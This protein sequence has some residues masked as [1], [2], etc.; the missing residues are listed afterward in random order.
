MSEIFTLFLWA[1]WQD[2]ENQTSYT[3][4][5]IIQETLY[6]DLRGIKLQENGE[7]LHN[8]ELHNLHSSPNI[9]MMKSRSLK[10]VG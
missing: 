2:F 9:R 6:L 4:K 5:L 3:G 8:E 10:L 7:K 1:F